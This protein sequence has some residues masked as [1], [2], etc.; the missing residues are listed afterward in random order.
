MQIKNKTKSNKTIKY[1][2]SHRTK[3]QKGRGPAFSTNRS[4]NEEALT[5][6]PSHTPYYYDYNRPNVTIPRELSRSYLSPIQPVTSYK[7]IPFTQ[8]HYSDSELALIKPINSYEMLRQMQRNN[9]TPTSRELKSKHTQGRVYRKPLF[10]NKEKH[11]GVIDQGYNI[12]NPETDMLPL[13]KYSWEVKDDDHSN[14]LHEM[15]EARPEGIGRHMAYLDTEGNNPPSF[16]GKKN[17]KTK[18][19]KKTLKKKMKMSVK[20]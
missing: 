18:K 12:F 8:S 3:K 5:V 10:A 13:T 7:T 6:L 1:K 19:V 4:I 17:K 20:K 11:I 16:G 14:K 2:N 15:E 9:M